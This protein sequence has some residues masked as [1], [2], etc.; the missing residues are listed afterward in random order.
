MLARREDFGAAPL[1]LWDMSNVTLRI[2]LKTDTD[3]LTKSNVMVGIPRRRVSILESVHIDRDFPVSR[4]SLSRN[5]EDGSGRGQDYSLLCGLDRERRELVVRWQPLPL[6]RWPHKIDYHRWPD[7][8][9]DERVID[10][11][12]VP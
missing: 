3:W 4:L 7:A 2:S 1:L 8:L 9:S 5:V 6:L 11:Q 10:Y 12:P